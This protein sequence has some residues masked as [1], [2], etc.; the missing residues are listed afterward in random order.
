ME[1]AEFLYDDDHKLIQITK[2]NKQT[3]AIRTPT[4]NNANYKNTPSPT[5]LLIQ[6]LMANT[7]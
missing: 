6:L 5:R 3:D 7:D 4:N 1:Y 2:Q